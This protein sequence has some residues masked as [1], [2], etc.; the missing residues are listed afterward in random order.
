M[1]GSVIAVVVAGAVLA[2]AAAG[3]LIAAG[4]AGGPESYRGSPPPPGIGLA[5]FDLRSYTGGRVSAEELRG[6]KV[7]A[8]T[9]LESRCEEACPIIARQVVMALERLTAEER[10][11]V[12]A[13]AIST[14]PDD[15]TVASVRAFLA[16]HHALGKLDYLVGSAAELRPVWRRF[17]VLSA[18]D[19]GDADT[20]SGSVH[21]YDLR[22]QW[23]S[24]LHPGIDLT[25]A[26]LAHDLK[27]ALGE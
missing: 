8:L 1:R 23:V 26:N 17:H 20:H 11:S 4:L 22:G 19:S 15:D 16:K 7:V 3:V 12:A 9:F 10:G 2:A 13:V 24:S 27:L 25:A 6:R 14:Q 21:V 5:D 18:L